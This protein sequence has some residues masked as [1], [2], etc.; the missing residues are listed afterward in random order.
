MG[1]F[2]AIV[3]AFSNDNIMIGTS[4]KSLKV[5]FTSTLLVLGIIV[6]PGLSQAQADTNEPRTIHTLAAAPTATVFAETSY[7]AYG[8]Y[9]VENGSYWYRDGYPYPGEIGNNQGGWGFSDSED[10]GS[11]HPSNCH[12]NIDPNG[13]CFETGDPNGYRDFY[14]QDCPW[15]GH[16]VL[17]PNNGYYNT[18]YA[19]G[20]HF[21][22]GCYWCGYGWYWGDYGSYT[23]Y[24]K[25]VENG[26]TNGSRGHVKSGGTLGQVENPNAY[27]AFFTSDDPSYYPSGVQHD[28]SILDIYEG[29]WTLCWS[30]NYNDHNAVESIQSACNGEYTIMAGSYEDPHIQ[31]PTVSNP[32]MSASEGLVTSTWTVTDRDQ[33]EMTNGVGIITDL[34]SGHQ[35]TCEI[36]MAV[37]MSEVENTVGCS[38][39][40]SMLQH[41]YS[42][43][44]SFEA[45]SFGTITGGEMSDKLVMTDEFQV[46]PT[47]LIAQVSHEAEVC[48]YNAPAS[49]TVM[50]KVDRQLRNIRT[51]SNGYACASYLMPEKASKQV[52]KASYG[53]IKSLESIIYMPIYKF[54]YRGGKTPKMTLE[55][56]GLPKFAR[57]EL[58]RVSRLS[59]TEVKSQWDTTEAIKSAKFLMNVPLQPDTYDLYVTLNKAQHP[60]AVLQVISQSAGGGIRN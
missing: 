41:H 57:V 10:Y 23:Q 31:Q 26:W 28:V 2:S 7:G 47:R 60:G 37:D 21:Y 6:A 44:M 55:T 34:E 59:G 38:F 3:K 43:S 39:E 33:V 50:I 19:Y 29:G 35:F 8:G 20:Y 15:N 52:V 24:Y 32:T 9:N 5:I 30:G 17:C 45:F 1:S 58:S 11:Y 46:I 36:D 14:Q 54:V 49:K 40:D 56:K 53:K 16:G 22:N 13:L 25:N 42:L 12:G 48:V 4:M 51:D 18:K 27:R